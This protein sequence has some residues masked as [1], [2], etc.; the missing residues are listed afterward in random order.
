MLLEIRSLLARA[1][2]NRYLLFQ[3]LEQVPRTCWDRQA[4]GDAWSA[5]HHLA[6]LATIDGVTMALLTPPTTGA[7][8]LDPALQSRRLDDLLAAADRAI[9]DL[10][11]SLPL[12]RTA[13]ASAIGELDD[14][15]LATPVLIDVP[16]AW[17]PVRQ[18]SMR[19]YLASWA[20]HDADHTS[21]IRQA[22][23]SPPSATDLALAARFG[24]RR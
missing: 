20:E 19:A 1:E 17:P 7:F 22:I 8:R 24:R 10:I 9:D 16:G 18:L 11:G 15:A 3:L 23:A 12:S 21:A 4:S 6:H 13:L 2:T 5:R 14:A